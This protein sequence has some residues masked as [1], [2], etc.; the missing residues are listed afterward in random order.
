MLYCSSIFYFFFSQ[1]IREC[2]ARLVSDQ[3]SYLLTYVPEI[4]HGE[5]LPDL[6][7][8]FVLLSGIPKSLE[9]VKAEF[10]ERVKQQGMV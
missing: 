5:R 4:V 6:S 1:F 7:N 9:P 2:E 8:L 10:K 3:M